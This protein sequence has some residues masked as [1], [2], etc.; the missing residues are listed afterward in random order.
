MN[1]GFQKSDNEIFNR[2]TIII[3]KIIPI[4]GIIKNKKQ[5][6]Q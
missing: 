2:I 5:Q 3:C 1:I 4:K 6:N